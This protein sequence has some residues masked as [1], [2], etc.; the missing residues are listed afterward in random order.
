M[1]ARLLLEALDSVISG[2]EHP[3]ELTG[4]QLGKLK[5]AVANAR[6]LIKEEIETYRGEVVVTWH[7]DRIVAVTRQDEDGQIL[8]I[9][10]E[11]GKGPKVKFPDLSKADQFEL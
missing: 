10:A 6:N 8:K 2:L 11:A 3:E 4:D 9:I 5:D 1:A 7:E